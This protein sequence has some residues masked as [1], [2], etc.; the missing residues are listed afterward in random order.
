MRSVIFL[1]AGAA[2]LVAA[3]PVSAKTGAKPPQATT[4]STYLFNDVHFHLTNYI[5]KGLTIRQYLAIM[6]TT[7]KRSAVF[8]IPVQQSWS[9]ANSGDFA[10]TYYLNTDAP[11]YYYSFVDAVIA[12]SYLSLPQKDRDRLD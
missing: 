4:Q 11:L 6:G 5:Q 3:A 10:P 8:G 9:Y 7:V 2:A 12:T 1:A